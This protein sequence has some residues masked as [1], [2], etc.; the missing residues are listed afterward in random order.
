MLRFPPYMHLFY[1]IF[2]SKLT[3][4]VLLSLFRYLPEDERF[5]YYRKDGLILYNAA[6]TDAVISL[7][8]RA[9][10]VRP[11]DLGVIEGSAATLNAL[12]EFEQARALLE[13]TIDKGFV[14][15]P[16]YAF[17]GTALLELGDYEGASES[18]QK[19]FEI[20]PMFCRPWMAGLNC[21]F[22]QGQLLRGEK[23]LATYV[24]NYNAFTSRPSKAQAFAAGNETGRNIS[25]DNHIFYIVQQIKLLGLPRGLLKGNTGIFFQNAT[26]ALGHAIL[27]PFHFLNLYR[28]RFDKIVVIG[29]PTGWHSKATAVALDMLKQYVVYVETTD[30][31]LLNLSWM[32]FGEYAYKN[33]TFVLKNYWG[34]CRDVAK[35]RS[36]PHA[37]LNNDR[38]YLSLPERFRLRGREICRRKGIDLSGKIVVLH[39]REHDYHKLK[40]QDYRNADIKNYLPAIRYLSDEG[41]LIVRVG[42]SS[43]SRR[44]DRS[45]RVI[46]LPHASYYEPF[47]DPFFIEHCDFLITCQSGPCGYG[48]VFG[49]PNLTLNAVYHYSLIP[50]HQELVAFKS[51][52]RR[53]EDSFREL[54]C[55]E[56][57]DD[58][59][60]LLENS[61]QFRNEGIEVEEMTADEILAAVKEM[62]RW[63]EN[64]ALP[65][66]PLQEK[67]RKITEEAAKR[68]GESAGPSISD[69]IGFSLPGYRLSDAVAQ[70]RPRYL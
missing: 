53:N 6:R 40:K 3:Q 25:T 38:Q 65:P 42:D 1:L 5:G 35:A 47:L 36:E 26:A 49:K 66:T 57:M 27:D 50:E 63:V 8:R 58:Q 7:L 64:P 60:Y 29:P 39:V 14:S 67:F 56:I 44:A 21:A 18:L 30:D 55:Q 11:G 62:V 54:S 28:G 68:R 23:G 31:F 48:R 2:S 15:A 45:L 59:L 43:M 16:V 24:A 13:S 69:Y 19:A 33:L 41:Y 61:M 10:E 17:Y 4:Y 46:D 52:R 9:V 37:V 22:S 34:L 70:M 20:D 12:Q 51:Y 32:N